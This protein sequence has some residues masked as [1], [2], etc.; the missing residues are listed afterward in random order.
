MQTKEEIAKELY[1]Q[2][3]AKHPD[4]YCEWEQQDELDRGFIYEAMERYASGRGGRE[5]VKASDCFPI[6]NEPS[7]LANVTVRTI[8]T[9]QS[10][11]DIWEFRETEIEGRGCMSGDTIP[12]TN[13]EW[14][15]ESGESSTSQPAQG[16][17]KEISGR[18]AN[19]PACNITKHG[20]KTRIA[21]VHT[22]G[23][24]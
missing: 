6:L 15:R 7:S 11:S 18:I 22:C 23:R 19:C 2:I 20:V 10:I 8:D 9:K 21:P 17:L 4:L 14:L 16:D 5:W 12:Y 1:D 24:K 3:R 13:I